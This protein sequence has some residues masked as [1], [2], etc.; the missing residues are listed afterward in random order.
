MKRLLLFV[1]LIGASFTQGSSTPQAA[2]DFIIVTDGVVYLTADVYMTA[3]Y[4]RVELLDVNGRTQASAI[5]SAG[6]T[7][8]FLLNDVSHAVR[9]TYHMD[10]GLEYVIV[11]ELS[12]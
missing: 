11:D 12:M 4:V 9:S 3:Q 10:S 5:T 1:L 2:P 8:S 7:V 6:S